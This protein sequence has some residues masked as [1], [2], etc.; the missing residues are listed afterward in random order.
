MNLIFDFGGVLIDWDPHHLYDPYFGDRSKTDWFLKNICTLE[1]NVQM[2]GGKPFAVG[3]A[4]LS[5][6]FPEWSK[7]IRMYFDEWIKMI[8]G[9]IPGM[10]D[11][12]REM[13]A[14][15]HGLYGL[16]NWSLETF[17]Q[18]KDDYPALKLLDGMVVSGNEGITKPDPAI[19]RLLLDRYSLRAEDCIF[20]DDNPTNAAAAGAVGIRGIRFTSADALR[21][22]LG[23]KP[24]AGA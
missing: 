17:C 4:E 20:I 2:D 18:V 1:W 13:K 19:Y 24:S 8:G 16:S 5:A 14:A 21:A 10:Y 15:G 12:V 11:F 22:E 3:I 6:K 7:E 23:L 9:P